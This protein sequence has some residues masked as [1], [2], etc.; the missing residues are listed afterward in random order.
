MAPRK[1]RRRFRVALVSSQGDRDVVIGD[2][3]AET[4][5]DA[6]AKAERKHRGFVHSLETNVWK[7]HAREIQV[8][9]APEAEVPQ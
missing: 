7:L 1:D 5:S 9:Q 4:A 2:Y 6:C 8:P 3:W